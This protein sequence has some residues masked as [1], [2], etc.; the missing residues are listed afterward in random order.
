MPE[1]PDL[2]IFSRNTA[3]QKVKH[4][5][6]FVDKKLNV[7]IKELKKILVDQ[8]IEKVCREGKEL[9]IKFK[10]GEVSGLHLM[11]RGQLYFFQECKRS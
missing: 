4:V 8:Q 10:N 9:H 5:K 2:Q 1:L 7:P 3:G 11:L 6:V